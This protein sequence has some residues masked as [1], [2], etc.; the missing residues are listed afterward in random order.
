MKRK[1]RIFIILAWTFLNANAHSPN[2][3]SL[4]LY[5]DNIF[6]GKRYCVDFNRIPSVLLD[7]FYCKY[8]LECNQT[9]FSV[10]APFPVITN[11]KAIKQLFIEKSDILSIDGILHIRTK[12]AKDGYLFVNKSIMDKI[13]GL[14]C[15]LDRLRI[16]YVYNNKVVRTKNDAMKLIKLREKHIQIAEILQDKQS[17]AITVYIIDK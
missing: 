9:N 3:D 6:V 11:P 2:S 12:K 1:I 7:N 13:A 10:N 16:S 15:D 5:I 8:L 17:G 4:I 14:D